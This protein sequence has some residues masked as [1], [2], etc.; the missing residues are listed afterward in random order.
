MNEWACQSGLPGHLLT[1]EAQVSNSHVNKMPISKYHFRPP[2]GTLRNNGSKCCWWEFKDTDSAFLLLT[3]MH[4]AAL[5]AIWQ[6]P[7][8]Y[9]WGKKN[10]S[11]PTIP[12][13]GICP[14][15][16]IKGFCRDV[17][18]LLVFFNVMYMNVLLACKSMYHSYTWHPWR[19]EKEVRY[20]GHGIT[21]TGYWAWVLHKSKK[22]S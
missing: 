6:Y 14:A 20:L 4:R 5:Q 16:I 13:T 18:G 19:T 15:E 2:N 22:Y 9:F 17:Y 3:G 8:L 1:R 7:K 21:G 10:Y 11:D 12:L